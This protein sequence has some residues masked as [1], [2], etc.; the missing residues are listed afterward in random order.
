M[1]LDMRSDYD[2]SDAE[3]ATIIVNA[4]LSEFIDYGLECSNAKIIS[5]DSFKDERVCSASKINEFLEKRKFFCPKLELIDLSRACS[6]DVDL[7]SH[8]AKRFYRFVRTLKENTNIDVIATPELEKLFPILLPKDEEDDNPLEAYVVPLK[9]EKYS[10][11]QAITKLQLAQAEKKLSPELCREILEHNNNNVVTQRVIAA[12]D[13]QLS[14]GT[15]QLDQ[16]IPILAGCIAG[17]YISSSNFDA[18]IDMVEKYI[19]PDHIT[20]EDI[21]FCFGL[22]KESS[23]SEES[24]QRINNLIKGLIP[25]LPEEVRQDLDEKAALKEKKQQEYLQK[26]QELHAKTNEYS[27]YLILSDAIHGDVSSEHLRRIGDII[28]D[29]AGEYPSLYKKIL[30]KINNEQNEYKIKAVALWI[31]PVILRINSLSPDN[32]SRALLDTLTGVVTQNQDVRH[33]YGHIFCQQLKTSNDSEFWLERIKKLLNDN[34]DDHILLMNTYEDME[35][36][37]KL[38]P[39]LIPESL[40]IFKSTLDFPEIDKGFN[41]HLHTLASI[42]GDTAQEHPEFTD[43]AIEILSVLANIEKNSCDS[44]GK[45]YLRSKI[46]DAFDKIKQNE[47]DLHLKCNLLM[48]HE[49]DQKIFTD[50]VKELMNDPQTDQQHI[51]K[52]IE[53]R[54]NSGL[55][56]LTDEYDSAECLKWNLAVLKSKSLQNKSPEDIS[57]CAERIFKDG[58][59]EQ[60]ENNPNYDPNETLQVIY[61]TAPYCLHKLREKISDEEDLLI[62]QHFDRIP[63]EIQKLYIGECTDKMDNLIKTDHL[64]DFPEIAAQKLKLEVCDFISDISAS[65]TYRDER[66]LSG[67]EKWAEVLKEINGYSS[68]EVCALALNEAM[69]I[70]SSISRPGKYYACE[71]ACGHFYRTKEDIEPFVKISTDIIDNVFE[72]IR[73]Q[74]N[75]PL[76]IDTLKEAKCVGLD[77]KISLQTV[78]GKEATEA[79]FSGDENYKKL[80]DKKMANDSISAYLMFEKPHEILQDTPLAEKGPLLDEIRKNTQIDDFGGY[81]EWKKFP[82]LLNSELLWN[83]I[84]HCSDKADKDVINAVKTFCKARLD[85][86]TSEC[87]SSLLKSLMLIYDVEVQK[88]VEDKEIYSILYKVRFSK[89]SKKVRKS[90]KTI[91][92]DLKLT[93]PKLKSL[94]QTSH[95]VN[96][97]MLKPDTNEK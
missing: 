59:I 21:N 31:E 27:G 64:K 6:P 8:E 7:E 34:P 61:D 35:Q 92:S 47:I 71:R 3:K 58:V 73:Q 86:T 29:N 30:D 66:S 51:E 20:V 89:D 75:N 62:L 2:T 69:H 26:R 76:F 10:S 77:D 90:M 85:D 44:P 57:A 94:C 1:I 53:I 93:S 5:F 40:A 54:M 46:D 39:E 33:E 9:E 95:F 25:H 48:V 88:G 23:Q 68:P 22:L 55:D 91:Y 15:E 74:K 16:Y 70:R 14:E 50:V 11:L 79:F 19:S 67:I 43:A 60:L 63:K 13:T 24:Y 80:W 32:A 38:H 41:D 72:Q 97:M 84:R 52:A 87:S 42:V 18:I 49:K 96:R 78:M 83:S 4:S 28:Y 82:E 36:A 56:V 81:F 17:R 65:E 45:N 12:I 37:Y